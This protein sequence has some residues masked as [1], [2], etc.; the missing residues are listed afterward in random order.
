MKYSG[1]WVAR[2]TRAAL[3]STTLSTWA[4]SSGQWT[5][6]GPLPDGSLGTDLDSSG[7]DGAVTQST[8]D[9][10][11]DALPDGSTIPDGSVLSDA[12]GGSDGLAD[13][14]PECPTAQAL[15]L[16]V[17]NRPATA[18]MTGAD[19]YTFTLAKA[20][21]VLVRARASTAAPQLD[22]AAG[23]V[24]D[25]AWDAGSALPSATVI[26]ATTYTRGMLQAGT[27]TL[28][29]LWGSAAPAAPA[30]TFDVMTYIP[31][32]NA[33]CSNAAALTPADDATTGDTFDATDNSTGCAPG[34]YGQLF[35][36]VQIP[37]NTAWQI[38]ATPGG[39]WSI[40]LE[41]FQTC[42]S[43]ACI[44][45]TASSPSPG[46]PATL[47]VLNGSSAP[48]TYVIGA[49]VKSDEGAT[50]GGDFTLVATALPPCSGDATACPGGNIC[51]GGN[52]ESPGPANH[53]GMS[54]ATCIPCPS[55]PGGHGT[56]KCTG[57]TCALQCPT[58]YCLNAAGTQCLAWDA[59]HCGAG[60][61]TD[62][63]QGIPTGAVA[64]CSAQ[65]SC[66]SA[67]PASTCLSDNVC[68][69]WDSMHCGAMGCDDCTVGGPTGANASCSAGGTCKYAC[70]T[71][72]CLNAL[73]TRCVAWDA[74]HCGT[75]TCSDC[76]QGIPSGATGSCSAQG[77]CASACPNG[78]CVSGG[79]CVSW[80]S[81][82]CGP[83]GA[84]TD[85][86]A[87]APS[88]GFAFCNNAGMCTPVC[89]GGCLDSA[90]DACIT[91]G[92][93]GCP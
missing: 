20:E 40:T 66:S 14:A 35:Y 93:P 82:H 63:T 25:A 37:A 45:P 49:G 83:G 46:S 10:T 4:C 16:D 48:A 21:G 30:Y 79:S 68:V 71:G 75:G 76:T 15:T 51:C 81:M 5:L 55:D 11:L 36:T 54:G 39:T 31:A 28:R 87:M 27:Y 34:G 56:A 1:R 12:S 72:T 19:Y 91:L 6:H 32:T 17:I 73:G 44:T 61:C 59:S 8:M 24:C 38:A 29:F 78:M 53:C 41:A 64:S 33:S 9:A 86:T 7:S 90:N 88:G 65:G 52:C 70:P 50:G 85:C 23:T 18:S 43:S 60:S 26:G 89:P 80:D 57:A 67:C 77:A 58:G 84:C 2:A 69:A 22:L 3:L 92:N 42:A 13:G 74:T 47:Q 62:C